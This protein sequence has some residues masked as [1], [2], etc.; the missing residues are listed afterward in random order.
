MFSQAKIINTK[1]EAG[2]TVESMLQNLSRL[3]FIHYA[4]NFT[5]L[6]QKQDT[7]KVQVYFI[8]L[9]YYIH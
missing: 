3:V 7:L 5:S 8:K 1:F 6:R 9:S 2:S 4:W